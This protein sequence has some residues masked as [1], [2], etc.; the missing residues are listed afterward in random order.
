VPPDGAAA[1]LIRETGAG[2]VVAPEDIAG[3]RAALEEL[4]ARWRA[5]GLVGTPLDEE[6]RR[7]LSRETRVEELAELLRSLA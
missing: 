1:D 3:I 2:V 7:R 6:T 4:H 5:G